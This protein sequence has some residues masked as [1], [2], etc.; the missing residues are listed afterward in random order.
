MVSKILPTKN[1]FSGRFFRVETYKLQPIKINGH[2]TIATSRQEI[3]KAGWV[4]KRPNP[5]CITRS[6]HGFWGTKAV[7]KACQYQAAMLKTARG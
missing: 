4:G 5:D 6:P 2:T 3:S 1:G 7:L